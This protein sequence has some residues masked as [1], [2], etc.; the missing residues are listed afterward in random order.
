MDKFNEDYFV[1][2]IEKGLSLY[3]NYRWIP[4]LT[5]PFAH[6][7]VKRL[8]IKETDKILDFGCAMGFLVKGFRHLDYNA[9]GYDT[10]EYALNNVPSDIKEF[11]FHTEVWTNKRWN[12]II[13]K[14]VFEHI[15]YNQI[16]NTIKKIKSCSDRIFVA[17]PLSDNGMTYNEPFYEH[18]VTHIIRENLTWWNNIFQSHLIEVEFAGYEIKGIK[19]NW[20]RIEQSNGFFKLKTN[21]I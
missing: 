2:G 3:S 13:C 6:N 11:I 15:P 8:E 4:E 16:D 17:V 19:E 7:L 1:R 14:D 18:D 5:I 10:S 20:K 9:W 21:I 12:W